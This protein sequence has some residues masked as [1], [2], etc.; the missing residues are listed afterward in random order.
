[1]NVIKNLC[2]AGLIM[3]YHLAR[4]PVQHPLHRFNIVWELEK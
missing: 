3:F 1:M 4:S 2:G